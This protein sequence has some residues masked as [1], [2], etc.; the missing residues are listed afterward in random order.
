[1]EI[2]HEFV[3]TYSSPCD[4]VDHLDWVFGEA[5]RANRTASFDAMFRYLFFRPWFTNKTTVP[6]P[7]LDSVSKA[8]TRSTR[9]QAAD[10]ARRWQ[11]ILCLPCGILAMGL[12]YVVTVTFWIGFTLFNALATGCEGGF[13]C[14]EGCFHD[15]YCTDVNSRCEFFMKLPFNFVVMVCNVAWFLIALSISLAIMLNLGAVLAAITLS[16]WTIFFPFWITKHI[17][18]SLCFRHSWWSFWHEFEKSWRGT[19][20]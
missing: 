16:A 13:E 6:L 2:I 7:K 18:A 5:S 17:V 10:L 11:S 9:A 8:W 19:M 14:A 20:R 15:M 12:L 3:G 1:V 4:D